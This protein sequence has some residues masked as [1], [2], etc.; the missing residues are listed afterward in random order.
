MLESV[1]VHIL[2][3]CILEVPCTKNASLLEMIADP[4]DPADT[5]VEKM[6]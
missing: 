1:H 4:A 5:E 3:P 6:E 2:M